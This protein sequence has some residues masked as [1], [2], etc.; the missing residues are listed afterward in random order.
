[1]KDKRY[2]WV[3]VLLAFF[4]LLLQSSCSRL[5]EQPDGFVNCQNGTN[6]TPIDSTFHFPGDLL[7][8]K[9]D[10]SE[11]LTFNG[12]THQFT[13]IFSMP[14]YAIADV[15]PLSHDG[16]TLVASYQDPSDMKTLSV[17]VLSPEGITKSNKIVMPLLEQKQEKTVEWFSSD[18]VNNYY[19]QGSLFE[20]GITGDELSG[21]W[22]FNPY[23]L[24]WKSLADILKDLNIA[25]LSGVLI[26]PDLTKV[27]YVNSQ[28]HLAL[29]DLSRKE[30][31]WEYNDYD[32]VFPDE[33][34]SM[35]DDAVW[36]P[37][38]K[39]LASPLTNKDGVPIS[40][41]LDKNGEIINSI[42]S[43]NYQHGYSW[44]KDGQFLA[45]YEDRCNTIDSIIRCE[46]RPVIRIVATKDGLLRDLCSLSKDIL[47]AQSIETFRIIWSPDQQFMAYS[48]TNH[49]TGQG[50]I[51]L[52]KL[53]DPQ[54]RIIDISD[55]AL[56][57]LGWSPEHWNKARP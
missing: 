25:E 45:F 7:F 2:F 42:Y 50:G 43:G 1:M 54:I 39:M 18:W 53:N 19:L 10:K 6:P 23:K 3:I 31:L 47:P 55:D 37:D 8:I 35:L 36:S 40:L 12:E 4:M 34:S 44:S 5:A 41:V 15:S 30:N 51:F 24:E 32:G 9:R 26:S 33:Q 52:Q 22:L 20:E 16:K 48:S 17:I 11:I 28:Y 49:K 13:S 46:S 21:K 56:I 29:Y 57:L 27:L 38:G 14:D